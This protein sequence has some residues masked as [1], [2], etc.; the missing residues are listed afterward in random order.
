MFK[1][2]LHIILL[3]SA[4]FITPF[5]IAHAQSRNNEKKV[6]FHFYNN[7]FLL[8]KEYYNFIADA[9]T[10][11]GHLIR[12]EISFEIHENWRIYAGFEAVKFWGA[13]TKIHIHPVYHLNYKN[14]NHRFVFGTLNRDKSHKIIA[15]LMNPEFRLLPARIEWGM[16]YEYQ[17]ENFEAESWMDLHRFI[18]PEDTVREEINGGLGIRR[19]IILNRFWEIQ[20]PFQLLAH[21]RGGQINLKGKFAEGKN[22]TMTVLS[23]T[24]GVTFVFKPLKK[25]H[26]GI[27]SNYL[28]HYV[29]RRNPEELKFTQ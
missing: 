23:G 20:L 8:N 7:N 29:N 26:F 9:Y 16:Q 11:A 2:K 12:P 15:P 10:L 27:F 1:H 21:H 3:V 24:M 5:F 17:S 14:D 4:F 18:I 6:I 22:A 25:H 13:N 28:F 19:K